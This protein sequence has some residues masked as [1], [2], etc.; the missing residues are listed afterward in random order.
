MLT[1]KMARF[2]MNCVTIALVA[3]LLRLELTEA[4]ITVQKFQNQTVKRIA[5][6]DDVPAAGWGATLGDKGIVGRFASA[7]PP[8][9]CGPAIQPSPAFSCFALIRRGKCNF[10]VKA[11]NAQRAGFQA[12][13][14]YNDQNDDLIAMSGGPTSALVNIPA[15]FIGLT[16]G[17][18]INN[19]FLYNVDDNVTIIIDGRSNPI[20]WLD[21]YVWPFLG[22]VAFVFC[23][24]VTFTVY[25]W[26]VDRR[27]RQRNRLSTKNLKKIPLKKF[28]KGDP[29]DVCAIC[30]DDYEE[31]DELRILPCN[32][33]YHA[34]CV[35]PWLTNN[36]RQC[37]V[38]KR[39]VSP[40]GSETSS[41]ASVPINANSDANASQSPDENSPPEGEEEGRTG[42]EEEEEEQDE[43]ES[44]PLILRSDDDDDVEVTRP[45]LMNRL[46]NAW[47]SWSEGRRRRV[48]SQV[49]PAPLDGPRFGYG[50]FS[51]VPPE[52]NP[53]LPP[54]PARSFAVVERSAAAVGPSQLD[55]S[56][57]GTNGGEAVATLHAT[58]DATG[59]P[60]HATHDAPSV[61]GD[62]VI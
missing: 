29:Y 30:L 1:E 27:R 61:N 14:I 24:L 42:E 44:T 16:D 15:I 9:A 36:K 26:V 4:D 7:N 10:D 45:S 31:Q 19:S 20:N 37:P 48:S 58:H 50:S 59:S 60:P 18:Y 3:S 39:K 28:V 23:L 22:S 62:P 11:L 46:K 32:H 43:E 56:Y 53:T 51:E 25:K 12:A 54:P 2:N 6:F 40:N 35:D 5:E 8:D 41:Q 13:V 17:L 49:A 47:T 34:I 52:F 57:H 38:C 55:S 21:K 33:A